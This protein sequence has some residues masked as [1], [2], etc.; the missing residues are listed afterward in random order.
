MD[1]QIRKHKRQYWLNVVAGL[2]SI[3]IVGIV[4]FFVFEPEE[5]VSVANLKKLRVGMGKQEVKAILGSSLHDQVKKGEIMHWEVGSSPPQNMW[6][7]PGGFVYGAIVPQDQD[8]TGPTEEWG[9]STLLIVIQFD[10][11]DRITRIA[12]FPATCD[13]NW[14]G[15]W[16]R[17]IR[18]KI[19]YWRERWKI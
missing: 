16:S 13:E 19:R 14:S 5:Q 10:N 12:S 9:S 3:F 6:A 7:K 15:P 11:E 18:D 1:N 17:R 8:L 4:G 2:L